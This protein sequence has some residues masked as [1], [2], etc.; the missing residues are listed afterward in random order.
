MS[1][2]LA[3]VARGI[4]MA[5]DTFPSPHSTNQGKDYWCEN[6]I[7]VCEPDNLRTYLLTGDRPMRIMEKWAICVVPTYSLTQKKAI[8]WNARLLMGEIS[9]EGNTPAEAILACAEACV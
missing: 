5:L 3:N 9:Y 7:P 1:D 6:G 4:G 8:E 2:A